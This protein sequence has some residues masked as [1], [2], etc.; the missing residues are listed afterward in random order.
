VSAFTCM[1]LKHQSDGEN[2]CS[3]SNGVWIALF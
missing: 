3:V 2:I 1:L